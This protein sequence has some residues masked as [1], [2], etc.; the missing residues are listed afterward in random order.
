MK[1]WCKSVFRASELKYLSLAL[2]EIRHNFLTNFDDGVVAI[3][4]FFLS[5]ENLLF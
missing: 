4:I 5:L 2:H 3:G 1:N